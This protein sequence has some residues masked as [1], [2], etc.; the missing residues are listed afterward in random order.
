VP[1]AE[2]RAPDLVLVT[3]GA[4]MP[5]E[6]PESGLLVD[7]F[8]AIG[9]DARLVVWDVPRDWSAS[10][11]VLRT[12]WDYVERHAEFLDWVRATA[13]VTTLVN[14]LAVVEWNI[15]K[16]YLADLG[17]RGLAVVPCSLVARGAAPAEQDAARAAFGD[18][19]VVKPAIS[20]GA[21]GTIRT[22]ASSAQARE[23]L[24]ALVREGDAL[25][26]PYLPA[27]EAG[28][29][30]LVYLGGE[31][32]HA[33]RK[34]PAAGDFRVQH[35]HGGSVEPHRATVGERALA[36]SVLD[37]AGMTAY[38]R[39]DLVETAD[40]PVLMEAE[41]IDPEL[42][43]GVDDGAAPRFARVLADRLLTAR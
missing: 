34:R 22:A 16:R 12:P 20:A 6:D 23:H 28:E 32:S 17:R 27:I 15:H 13:A 7:A 3:G 42:F 40:G 5:V 41:L 9:V 30:S 10:P 25:V 31:L 2:A 35:E 14:P 29:V 11:V 37:V 24:A 26:Q 36:Q 18:E 43:L 19:I 38:A 8:A 4:R 33:V 39:I 21:F 1:A